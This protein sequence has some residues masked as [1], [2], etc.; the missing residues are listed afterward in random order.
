[1]KSHHAPMF[2]VDRVVVVQ[3]TVVVAD[4][5]LAD[6]QFTD[7]GDDDHDFIEIF[8]HLD[9]VPEFKSKFFP[10]IVTAANGGNNNR[11]LN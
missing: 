6:L 8:L 7:D 1:M 2:A 3:D 11:R 9:S 5:R 4:C 10:L